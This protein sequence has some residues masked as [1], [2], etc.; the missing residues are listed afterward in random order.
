[1][2]RRQKPESSKRTWF[3]WVPCSGGKTG[4]EESKLGCAKS[5]SGPWLVSYQRV[6]IYNISK[7]SFSSR[8]MRGMTKRKKSRGD[9]KILATQAEVSRAHS[10][11]WTPMI[12]QESMGVA[13]VLTGLKLPLWL[14]SWSNTSPSFK[15]WLIGIK[16]HNSLIFFPGHSST[17]HNSILP[18]TGAH[19]PPLSKLGSSFNNA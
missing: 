17:W 13:E 10:W 11:V 19:R 9:V 3:V 8:G 4:S 16:R 2:W 7:S 1:M 15:K 5:K 12:S 18:N 6:R 14:L